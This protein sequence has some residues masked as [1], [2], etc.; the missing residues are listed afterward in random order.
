MLINTEQESE[1]QQTRGLMR[2]NNGRDYSCNPKID[3]RYLLFHLLIIFM[4]C[5]METGRP[6]FQEISGKNGAD[7]KA[8]V[9]ASLPCASV[10]VFK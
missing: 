2:N 6:K 7:V 9:V 1:E 8:G 10:I 3:G 5:G 4:N